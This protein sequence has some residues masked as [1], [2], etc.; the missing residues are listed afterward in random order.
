MMHGDINFDPQKLKHLPSLIQPLRAAV[1]SG[2]KRQMQIENHAAPQ[3]LSAGLS[4]NPHLGMGGT[5]AVSE[6]DIESLAT[7]VS[8]YEAKMR[9][10]ETVDPPKP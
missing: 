9:N 6:T 7:K 5:R 4:V 1:A 10:K 2:I 3:V 8:R